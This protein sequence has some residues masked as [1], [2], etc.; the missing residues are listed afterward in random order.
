MTDL[1]K[2][3][4]DANEFEQ[5]GIQVVKKLADHLRSLD[6]SLKYHYQE[7]NQEKA[8]WEAYFSKPIVFEQLMDES[9]RRSVHLHH[10]HYIGHQISPAAP[11]A[12][13]GGLVAD[14]LN[15]G[16]GVY[17]MGVVSTAWEGIVID[18]LIHTVDYQG[19][20]SGFLTSGGSLANLTALLCARS[21]YKKQISRAGVMISEMAHYSIS[22]AAMILDLEI[23][24]VPV[25]ANY[26]M[27]TDTLEKYY[28]QAKALGTNPIAVVGNACSTA[29]GSFDDLE[30]IDLFCKKKELWFHVDGAHGG[31]MVFSKKYKHL[32]A[33][34]EKADSFIVD[35]HKML[36]TPSICT[37]IVFRDGKDSYR[38]YQHEADYLWSNEH[39][40]WHNLAKRTFEC[41]KFMMSFKVL[42][43]WVKYGDELFDDFVTTLNDL[44]QKFAAIIKQHPKFELAITPQCN[45]VCFRWTQSPDDALNNVNA[46]LR[47]K[48]IASGKFYIVQTTIEGQIYLRCAIM[49]P[50]TLVEHFEDLLNTLEHLV[51][52]DPQSI[53][54]ALN[55]SD[56]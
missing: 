47:Q 45:I 44:G 49:N 46:S 34:I 7:A 10:P 39:E 56:S 1:L 37:A 18:K 48:L 35:F 19:N 30:K 31:S 9:I 8:F 22:K 41:T 52:A 16:M 53:Q 55:K 21:K 29:T 26:A 23:I 24:R 4:Y 20:A 12:A 2:K 25:D 6:G 33:G 32:V 50:F 54:P 43:M 36:M 40:E 15:N 13:L 5:T 38:T 14:F 28:N 11:M 27:N 17:E 3:I 51:I 42:P